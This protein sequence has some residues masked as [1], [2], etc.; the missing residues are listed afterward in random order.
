MIERHRRQARALRN[1]HRLPGDRDGPAAGRQRGIRGDREAH[2]S[3]AATGRAQEDREERRRCGRR[4]GARRHRE[5]VHVERARG[6]ADLVTR[7]REPIPARLLGDG[8]R[9]PADRQHRA[10]H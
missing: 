4:P 2:R 9:L 6:A 10:S 7:L 3:P 5:D 8:E 1:R